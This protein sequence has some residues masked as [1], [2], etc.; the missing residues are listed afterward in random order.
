MSN[1][2]QSVSR[3]SRF[4]WILKAGTALV[5]FAEKSTKYIF[6]DLMDDIVANGFFDWVSTTCTPITL[7]MTA[8]MAILAL[9]ILLNSK[10][11]LPPILRPH[12]WLHFDKL[13]H[14]LDLYN[15]FP[16]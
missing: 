2:S 6:R 9:I 12:L 14:S 4:S 7:A 5:L 8:G 13:A 10:K 11:G 15:L 16:R 1:N 3:P